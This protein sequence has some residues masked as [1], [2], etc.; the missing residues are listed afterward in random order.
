MKKSLLIF[1]A[2]LTVASSSATLAAPPATFDQA[3]VE[4]RQAVY[5]DRN[6]VGDLYCG[7]PWQ[8]M[9]R[10]GGRIDLQACGYQVRAQP[11]RA[12]RIEWEHIVPT[13][14]L[15]HQRQCWQKGGRSNCVSSDPVF[16]TMEAD[17]HNLSPSVGEVNADRSNYRLGQLTST[18]YQYG[19][20]QTRVDFKQRMAEPRDQA[21]GQ[22]ARI[23][24]YMHD[25]YGLSMSKQQQ[26]LFSAWHRQYP[27]SPW[28]LE[29]DP[30]I[31][32]VM[33]HNNLF[34][35]GER[36]WSIGQ[37]PS[38]EGLAQ[39]SEQRNSPPGRQPVVLADV[40]AQEDLTS[41]PAIGNRN[42]KVYHLPKGCPSYS[43][44]GE[45]NQV[46]FNSAA[47]AEAAGFRLAGN[48]R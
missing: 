7:C 16:R 25:R 5:F 35:T 30:R 22:M 15:G 13:W 47:E 33:G 6:S 3:K 42:S 17:M 27:V 48:C 14:V 10:S 45:R 31:P 28:E 2:V 29:R 44:V 4:L 19:A 26:Q 46:A 1:I 32:R 8:W 11:T 12:A 38:D 40:Q 37:R 34:V 43:Q 23:Y 36:S 9:G 39:L 24:F 41:T 20:C 21:K 18:P